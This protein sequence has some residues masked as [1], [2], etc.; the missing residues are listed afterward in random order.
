M[1]IGSTS[2]PCSIYPRE[3]L[4]RSVAARIPARR[5]MRTTV[6]KIIDDIVGTSAS[7]TLTITKGK[8]GHNVSDANLWQPRVIHG[9]QKPGNPLTI[10]HIPTLPPS[11]LHQRNPRGRTILKHG[12]L[13]DG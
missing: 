5:K 2:M 12:F 7:P 13:G 6:V 4:T 3:N 11:C 10:A 9:L 1:W 8:Y